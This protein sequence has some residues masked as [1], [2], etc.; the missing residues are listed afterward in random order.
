[1]RLSEA[2]RQM[3]FQRHLPQPA[4][5]EK[6]IHSMAGIPGSGKTT[7]VEKAMAAGTFPRAAFV[8]DPDRV[9]QSLPEYMRDYSRLGAAEAFALWEMPAR[10]LAYEM[11]ENAAARGL[12]IVK[13]MGCARQENIDMLAAIKARGYRLIVHYLS[14]DVEEALRRIGARERHTPENLVRERDASIRMLL[15]QLRALADEFYAYKNTEGGY[16][17]D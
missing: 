5:A 11:A 7:F 2:S 6:I 3:M 12:P 8:L 10:E 4:A 9:M 16:R 15:P 13:D 17:P 14:C 1:M